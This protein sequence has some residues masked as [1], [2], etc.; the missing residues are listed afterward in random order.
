LPHKQVGMRHSAQLLCHSWLPWKTK[1]NL[2]WRSSIEKEKY[3]Q[4]R[5][6]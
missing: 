2:F 5:V 4:R 3:K 1:R 6:Q